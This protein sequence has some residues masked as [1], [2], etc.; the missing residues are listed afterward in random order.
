MA[1]TPI[2]AILDSLEYVPTNAQPN[3]EGIPYVTHEG[4]LQLGEISIK[5]CVLNTGKRIIPEDEWKRV[6]GNN[7]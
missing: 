1:K 2:E 3:E 7:I 4:V 6:L 5:V